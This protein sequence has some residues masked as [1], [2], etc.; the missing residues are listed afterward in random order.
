MLNGLLNTYIF[1]FIGGLQQIINIIIIHKIKLIV[2]Y[3]INNLFILYKDKL[4]FLDMC[5]NVSFSV[6]HI[7]SE[8]KI[9]IG[10]PS[11]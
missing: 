9:F 8:L 6:I 5:T 4:T 7:Y 2:K 3:N 11:I 1:N 10:L